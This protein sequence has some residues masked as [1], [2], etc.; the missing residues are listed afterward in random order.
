MRRTLCCVRPSSKNK[1]AKTCTRWVKLHGSQTTA[2]VTG[3]N[4]F[5]FKGKVGGRKLAPGKYQVSLVATDPSGNAA[6]PVIVKFTV[7]PKKN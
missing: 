2:A 5:S 7:L 6:A 4:T 3:M 1:T